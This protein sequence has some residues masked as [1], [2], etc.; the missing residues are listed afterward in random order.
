MIMQPSESES[1]PSAEE[2]QS[3][4]GCRSVSAVS[5]PSGLDY[6]VRSHRMALQLNH[7][8]FEALRRDC[9]VAFVL[10]SSNW[11]SAS[12]TPSA[13]G[14]QRLAA[15]TRHMA[16]VQ[17]HSEARHCACSTVTQ[18]PT[19]SGGSGSLLLDHSS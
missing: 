6:S 3:D 15:C 4:A 5:R 14:L 16:D 7:D 1:E 13:S 11:L 10:N 17:A 12:S 8:V 9:Q 2:E 19:S 18:R